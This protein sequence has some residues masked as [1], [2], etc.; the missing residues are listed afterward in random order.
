[1]GSLKLLIFELHK[2]KSYEVVTGFFKSINTYENIRICESSY[3]LRTYDHPEIIYER[4]NPYI[5][6]DDNVLIFSIKTPYFGQHRKTI[7]EWLERILQ[8]EHA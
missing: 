3:I 1:M 7:V 8:A 5:D 6:P 4:L 2:E